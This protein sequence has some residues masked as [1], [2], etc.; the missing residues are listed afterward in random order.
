MNRWY[1]TSGIYK[2]VAYTNPAFWFFLALYAVSDK[3]IKNENIYKYFTWT[4]PVFYLYVLG[5]IIG[6]M[7]YDLYKGF[8]RLV[9]VI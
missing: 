3:R 7:F 9:E 6:I 2:W 1:N 5:Y 8:K 4:Q